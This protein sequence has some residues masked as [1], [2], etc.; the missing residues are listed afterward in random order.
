MIM[1]ILSIVL[2]LFLFVSNGFGQ[3]DYPDYR[4]KK[5][6]FSKIPDKQIRDELASF[7]MAGVEESIGKLSLSKVPVSSYGK[8]YVSF[9]GNN[10]KVIV[11][12][13]VFNPAGH[14][15]QKV[16]EHVVKIDNKPFYGNYGN[17]PK[18]YIKSVSVVIGTDSVEIPTTAYFDLYDLNFGY[19]DASGTLR[20]TDGIY[21]S[22]DKTKFYIYLLNRSPEGNYEVTWVIQDKKYLRRVLDYG[23]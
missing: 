21:F 14:K 11:Y 3:L 13:A 5:E 23:F 7:T 2:F 18:T 22:S 20:S 15:L 4:Q 6:S 12:T 10:V 9:N 19:R 1:R 16:D 8:D 17:L